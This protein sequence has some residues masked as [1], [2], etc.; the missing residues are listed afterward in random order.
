MVIDG[1]GDT[2]RVVNKHC[3]SRHI[4]HKVFYPLLISIFQI[5]SSVCLIGNHAIDNVDTSEH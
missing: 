2:K 4:G 1:G 5:F 3:G